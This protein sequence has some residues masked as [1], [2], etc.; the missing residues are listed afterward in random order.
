MINTGQTLCYFGCIILI[1]SGVVPID[2][3]FDIPWLINVAGIALGAA[4]IISGSL[5]IMAGELINYADSKINILTNK[6]AN[7]P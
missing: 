4:L 2:L 6:F 7:K 5:F 1:V 3:G